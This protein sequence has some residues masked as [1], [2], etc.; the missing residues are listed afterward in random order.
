MFF[1]GFGTPFPQS[2]TALTRSQ[3]DAYACVARMRFDRIACDAHPLAAA[4]VATTRTHTQT[5]RRT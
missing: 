3:D 2:P 5:N 1:F 4:Q